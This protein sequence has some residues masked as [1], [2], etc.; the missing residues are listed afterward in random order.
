VGRAAHLSQ[1]HLSGKGLLE[2]TQRELHPE[3]APHRVVNALSGDVAGLYGAGHGCDVALVV[4]GHHR[5][6]NP[7]LMAVTTAS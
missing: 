1:Q 6:V 5:H 2:Q 7:A 4:E 3:N